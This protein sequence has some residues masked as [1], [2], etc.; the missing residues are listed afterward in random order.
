M[1][2]LINILLLTI[3]S[4]VLARYKHKM[5]SKKIFCILATIQWVLISG[6]RGLSVG[7]DTYGY[8]SGFDLRE[9]QSWDFLFNDFIDV[10]FKNGEGKDPGYAILEKTFHIFSDS[11]QGW[12]MFIAVLFTVS[13]GVW[14]YKN[15][16][17]PY[18][19]FLLYSALFYAFFAITGH[20]QTIATAIVVFIG[21][22]FLKEHKLIK[23]L[24]CICI[25]YPIHKSSMVY[26]L[27]YVVTYIPVNKKY[28]FAVIVTTIFMFIFK[29]QVM[30]FLALNT[31]YDDYASQYEGAG[32]YNFTFMYCALFALASWRFKEAKLGNE[33]WNI[34]FHAMLLGMMFIPLTYVRPSAMRVVQYFSVYL[35]LVV[36]D[37]SESFSGRD[38]LIVEWSM[39]VALILLLIMSNPY[40]VFFW[41]E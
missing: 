14:I 33:N 2:Y 19:S 6:L 17:D 36:S 22:K 7:A 23:F 8:K 21:Y 13:M 15:S 35:M 32:T 29:N 5:N 10:L 18:L 11:Y 31:G 20:R 40:Y 38:K 26:A 24:I 16:K 34:E 3:E 1:V 30:Q 41:Q 39:A 28:I 37:I 9:Y 12:L 27:L 25:A 4:A